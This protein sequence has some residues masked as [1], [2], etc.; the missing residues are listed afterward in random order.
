MTDD[1]PLDITGH[2]DREPPDDE[3][4]VPGGEPDQDA[5]DE[6]GGDDGTSSDDPPLE[7]VAAPVDDGERQDAMDEVLPD[8]AGDDEE[9][10][11]PV[12]LL[13]QL[14]ENGEIDPWDVDVVTVTEE[15]LDALDEGDLRASG[16]ALFYAS[17]LIR[18]KGDQLLSDDDPE[19]PEPEPWEVAMEGGDPEHPPD[20]D[21]VAKL[22]QEMDRRLDR[23]HARGKPETLD[24]L[25]RELREAERDSWWKESRTYD[26]S[27]SPK[28]FARGTQTLDYH[29][30]DD[31]RQDDEPSASDVTSTAHEEDIE[32]TIDDV[33]A[34]LQEHYDAGRAEVLFAEVARTGGDRVGTFLAVLFLSHRGQIRL[35]QDELFGDLWLQDP[36]ADVASGE[37]AAD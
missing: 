34:A 2:D 9:G 29:A 4:A 21:P 18:M 22:E 5:P 8:H 35:Q 1:I 16:R 28:G 6:R 10:A 7:T 26:T 33:R 23:K 15:F 20:Y 31:L 24:E 11:E 3:D 36:N 30:A 12:E 14:A 19:E 13:V 27:E 32:A 17:V 25:V 37:V